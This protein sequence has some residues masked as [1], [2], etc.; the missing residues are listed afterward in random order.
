MEAI[1]KQTIFK[2]NSI[3]GES[4]KRAL[5]VAVIVG[6]VL[7]LVNN[8]QLFSFSFS[9]LNS[10]KVTLT[11]LIPFCVSLYSSV[12]A[13]RSKCPENKLTQSRQEK[14]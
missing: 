10:Y 7:N 6:I 8:P 5:R 1:S 14:K 12:L 4:L 13:N 2:K 3:T 9:G 11:F